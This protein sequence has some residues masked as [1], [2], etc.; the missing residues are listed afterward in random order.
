MSIDQE[1][2]YVTFYMH[3]V[4]SKKFLI[5]YNNQT[6]IKLLQDSNIIKRDKYF[7]ISRNPPLNKVNMLVNSL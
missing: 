4:R 2:N 6:R 1:E 5:G 7:K 3:M